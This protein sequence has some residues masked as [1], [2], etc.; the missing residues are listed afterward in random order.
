[1]RV[2]PLVFMGSSVLLSAGAV[3]YFHEPGR[4]KARPAKPPEISA[5]IDD[6]RPTHRVAVYPDSVPGTATDKLA[7]TDVDV[8]WARLNKDGIAALESGANARAVEL[9]EQ[10]H[11]A[12]ANEP[13]FTNNLAEA[14]ARL[15]S[16]EFDR[17]GEADRKHAIEH[18]TRA[19]ELAPARADLRRRLD[20]MKALAKSEEGMWTDESEHFQLSYDGDRSDLL[21]GSSVITNALEGAYQQYGEYFGSYPVER[22]RAKIRVVLYKK[23]GFHE[24]TGIGHW[25]GGLY[26]G[27]V[28][29]PVEDLKREKNVLTRILRHELAHAFVHETGGRDV[30]GWLNEGL[31]QR[32]ECES[33]AQAQSVLESTRKLLHGTQLIPLDKLSGSLGDQKEDAAITQAYRQSLAFVAWIQSTYGERVP[34]EMVAGHKSG[35]VAAA[36]ER[37]TGVKLDVAFSDFADGL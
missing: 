36:F 20:Q 12:V 21:G 25:A 17:G 3:Y 18:M 8:R 7:S 14:L 24:A 4:P 33:M 35:G 9:F 5:S 31:A 15:S 2:M 29:V 23:D 1:M 26:D 34:Y 32:L 19:V 37:S 22:G 13:V 11:A 30:L 10:C 28:R 6:E 16:S 27:A